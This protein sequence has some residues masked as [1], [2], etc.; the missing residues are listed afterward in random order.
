MRAIW[1]IVASVV[2]IGSPSSF[3]RFSGNVTENCVD[4]ATFYQS[5]CGPRGAGAETLSFALWKQAF[6]TGW[7]PYDPDLVEEY[8]GLFAKRAEEL[9]GASSYTGG[10]LRLAADA[11]FLRDITTGEEEAAPFVYQTC[12]L[13]R[14]SDGGEFTD[15]GPGFGLYPAG[16]VSQITG[17]FLYSLCKRF[18]HTTVGFGNGIHDVLHEA[19]ACVGDPVG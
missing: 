1:L 5:V 17:G 6:R 13:M 19:L 15:I 12:R 2:S 11:W 9:G 16:S 10:V 4:N 8:A 14:S 7:D 3:R 18:R